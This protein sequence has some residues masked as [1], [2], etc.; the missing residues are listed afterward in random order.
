MS[1][2]AVSAETFDEVGAMTPSLWRQVP[3]ERC[4]LRFAAETLAA[5]RTSRTLEPDAQGMDRRGTNCAYQL[6]FGW[7]AV[8]EPQKQLVEPL[9]SRGIVDRHSDSEA[10][11]AGV[12]V[13]DS[14]RVLL[15]AQK[16]FP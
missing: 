11:C 5:L 4:C 6:S 16:G 10:I 9:E 2:G 7:I 3:D 1:S 13:D 12:E 8:R 15:V 14:R